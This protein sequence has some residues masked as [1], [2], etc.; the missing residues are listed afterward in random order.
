MKI[1]NTSYTSEALMPDYL[2]TTQLQLSENHVNEVLTAE[3]AASK[4]KK[5]WGWT[6]K[7]QPYTDHTLKMAKLIGAQ[8]IDIATSHMGCDQRG[9]LLK[10]PHTDGIFDVE[11]SSVYL[12]AI[13]PGHSVF[14]PVNRA[15]GWCGVC[16]LQCDSDSHTVNIQPRMGLRP[17]PMGL[18]LDRHVIQPEMQKLVFFPGVYNFEYT[19][20]TSKSATVILQANIIFKKVK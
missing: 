17:G 9:K 13:K 3:A 10:M 15:T 12:N 19:P 16:W 7:A 6:R 4:T 2:Y 1:S 14:V 18:Y 5:V 20:G 11:F 8:F